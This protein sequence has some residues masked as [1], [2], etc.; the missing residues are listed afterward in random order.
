[1]HGEGVTFS[2]CFRKGCAV[3]RGVRVLCIRDRV[4][5]WRRESM[6]AWQLVACT[7]NSAVGL[8]SR[9]PGARASSITIACKP[10]PSIGSRDS[11]PPICW[12][13]KD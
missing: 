1:M 9:K 5:V 6:R 12:S 10:H 7:S 3:Q 11:H 4:S 2:L 8:S 13:G